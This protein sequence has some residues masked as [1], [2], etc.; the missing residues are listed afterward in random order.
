MAFALR[1]P[2]SVLRCIGQQVDTT[3]LSLVIILVCACVYTVYIVRKRSLH[4]HN[5]EAGVAVSPSPKVAGTL[6]DFGL[7]HACRQRALH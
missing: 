2:T 6:L 4:A 3:V 7:R 1:M 5:E